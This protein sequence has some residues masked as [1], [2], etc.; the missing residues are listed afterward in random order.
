MPKHFVSHHKSDENGNPA[1]G[2]TSS[3]G[4][5]INWQNGPLGRG[6]G[7][8]QPNGAF[9]ETVIAGVIDRIEY[10]E[11]AGFG[12]SE[13]RAANASLRRALEYLHRRT[14]R[15]EA[16]GVE[17]T[18]ILCDGD[19]ATDEISGVLQDEYR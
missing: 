11:D 1:G 14:K 7:R 4:I 19:D 16:G 2:C 15:R 8:L 5:A 3:I 13:Y 10:Y 6:A 9:V 17:G 12:C 18:H